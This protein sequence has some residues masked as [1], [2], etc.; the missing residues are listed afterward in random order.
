MDVV[1]LP[2]APHL[3]LILCVAP[4][5]PQMPRAVPHVHKCL[6]QP[7][8]VH[9]CHGQPPH[10]HKWHRQP[11]PCP[12][13]PWAAPTSTNSLGS[14]P[15]STNATG[16]PLPRPQMPRAAPSHVHRCFGQP[17]HIHKCLGQPPQG[18]WSGGR[19]RGVRANSQRKAP[20]FPG[21]CAADEAMENGPQRT[22][23]PRCRATG[24]APS[25]A[26]GG[27]LTLVSQAQAGT[28]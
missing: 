4:T 27:S 16:S 17:P 15:T 9:K 25:R 11:P 10:V 23:A 22:A 7:P 21:K 6:G 28:R 19:G 3:H 8:Q 5:R 1:K 24:Q 13:M 18:S 14:P 20:P 2:D 26:C 12:Q